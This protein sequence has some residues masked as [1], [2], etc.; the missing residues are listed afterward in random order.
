MVI[1]HVLHVALPSILIITL[2]LVIY[3]LIP[4]ILNV[5]IICFH[6]R[7][8][9][10]EHHICV[11]YLIYQIFLYICDKCLSTSANSKTDSKYVDL[12]NKL[13]TI[14]N[15][16]DYISSSLSS[17]HNSFTPKVFSDIVS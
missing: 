7:N 3:V 1:C 10:Q 15:V 16:C 8:A 14:F 11:A 9:N 5:F 2:F 17:L 12:Q 13:S 4:Y 6:N